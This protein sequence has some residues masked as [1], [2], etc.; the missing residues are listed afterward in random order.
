MWYNIGRLESDQAGQPGGEDG[1]MRYKCYG[2]IS[3]T[4]VLHATKS[5][6]VS[7]IADSFREAREIIAEWLRA[8]HERSDH[9]PKKAPIK[10]GQSINDGEWRY[11]IE[12]F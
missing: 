12:Q 10:A 7:A 8:D 3:E 2:E 1:M 5:G 9:E 4:S 11:T 6:F